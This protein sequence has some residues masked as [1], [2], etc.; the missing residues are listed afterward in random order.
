MIHRITQSAVLMAALVFSFATVALAQGGNKEIKKSPIRMTS[1]NSGKEMFETYCAVCHGT[2]ARGDG[3]AAS[4]FKK[5]PANLTL[6][7][8]DHDG[9]YPES[10]VT[11]VIQTGPRDAKAHGSKDMP[12]WGKLFSSLGDAATVKLRIF[13]LNKYI[14]SLQVK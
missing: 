6:L 2:D 9:K 7:A 11:E 10:Y 5:A 14:E 12:V 13:N 3:P 8:R 1:A 4:E